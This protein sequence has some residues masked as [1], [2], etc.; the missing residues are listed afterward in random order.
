MAPLALSRRLKYS[1]GGTGT[2]PYTRLTEEHPFVSH[3]VLLVGVAHFWS[4]RFYSAN[5]LYICN[6]SREVSSVYITTLVR[7]HDFEKIILS[8]KSFT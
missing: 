3:S 7:T 4:N 8:I 5:C 2:V 6:D 1:S